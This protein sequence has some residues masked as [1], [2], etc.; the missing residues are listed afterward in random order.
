MR[1][2]RSEQITQAKRRETRI[3]KRKKEEIL[4]F[5]RSHMCACYTIGR[6]PT[7]TWVAMFENS[8]PAGMQPAGAPSLISPLSPST[9]P[10]YAIPQFKARHDDARTPTFVSTSLESSSLFF[11]ALLWFSLLSVLPPA[12]FT[13]S[14]LHAWRPK[15][16]RNQR[17]ASGLA[18]LGLV[19]PDFSA[20]K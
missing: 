3:R 18:W 11:F 19:A 9:M 6:G 20:P 4:Q 17:R 7:F 13:S 14:A 16:S 1:G 2:N 15:W 10:P 12:P 5:V 8:R